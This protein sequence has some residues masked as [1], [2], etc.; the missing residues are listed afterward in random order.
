MSK[1]QEAEAMVADLKNVVTLA[2]LDQLYVKWIGYSIVEDDPEASEASVRDLLDA[3]ITE[4]RFQIAYDQGKVDA[5]HDLQ[6][7]CVAK[8][9]P[10]QARNM[11]AAARSQVGDSGRSITQADAYWF[12]YRLALIKD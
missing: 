4:F 1:I 10:L 3:Y 9:T 11:V 8:G 6:E 5:E 7:G 12:G 2:D